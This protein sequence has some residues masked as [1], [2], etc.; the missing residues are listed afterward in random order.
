MAAC[1][2]FLRPKASCDFTLASSYDF[3][4]GAP[5]P[6]MLWAKRPARA[7]ASRAFQTTVSQERTN[8]GAANPGILSIECTSS[9]ATK[10]ASERDARLN[11]DHFERGIPDVRGWR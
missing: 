4:G 9:H 5:R 3:R 8:E 10:V 11:P 1:V 2:H 6:G 7:R